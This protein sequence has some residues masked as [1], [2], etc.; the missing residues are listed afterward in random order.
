VTV[1]EIKIM[2]SHVM[3]LLVDIQKTVTVSNLSV[4][5]EWR[6]TLAYKS[7]MGRLHSL[8]PGIKQ[9]GGYYSIL[10]HWMLCL[11]Y[12]YHRLLYDFDAVR[13]S[14]DAEIND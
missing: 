8:E 5:D 6:H 10:L 14:V 12:W 3:R 9:H 1:I 11:Q 4:S 7:F 13:H 2:L